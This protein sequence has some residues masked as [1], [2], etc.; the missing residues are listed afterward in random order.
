[1]AEFIAYYPQTTPHIMHRGKSG[2]VYRLDGFDKCVRIKDKLTGDPKYELRFVDGKEDESLARQL[3]S[4]AHDPQ[5][6]DAYRT[7][8]PNELANSSGVLWQEGLCEFVLESAL[9]CKYSVDAALRNGVALAV[10][11]GGHHAEYDRPLGF[12]TVNTM[13]IAALYAQTLGKR[14]AL[15]DCDVHYS[16]GCF[17]ILRNKDDIWVSS[18]WNK[19]VDKWKY[20][21]SGRNIWQRKVNTAQEYFEALKELRQSLSD[22]EPGFGV[23]HLGMDVLTMDRMGGVEGFTVEKLYERE[24]KIAEL[25]HKIAIPYVIFLGGAYIDY[26]QG[27]EFAIAQKKLV[28]EY[29]EHALKIHAEML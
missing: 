9:S 2:N 3:I 11:G 20:Y 13:A 1:M 23:Y 6:I 12:G 18:I 10:V 7:G 5:I 25:M 19:K 29:Q 8:I 27:E 24:Q 22:F 17:D 26:S 16:N 28:T 14:S 4:L 15:V 21:E